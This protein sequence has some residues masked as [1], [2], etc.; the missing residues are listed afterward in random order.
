[1]APLRLAFVLGAPPDVGMVG[2]LTGDIVA[3]W[4]DDFVT[5]SVFV[6]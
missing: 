2:L 1:M 5:T 4:V 6:Y 3:D